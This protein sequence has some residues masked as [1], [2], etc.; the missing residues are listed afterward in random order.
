MSLFINLLFFFL[1]LVIL[2]GVP[3]SLRLAGATS[4]T[5]YPVHG[6]MH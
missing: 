1:S 4:V 6:R 2:K 5:T 3:D